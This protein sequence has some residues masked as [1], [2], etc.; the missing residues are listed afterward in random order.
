[1]KRIRPI[2]LF[3]CV[4]PPTFAQLPQPITPNWTEV[5][6]GVWKT[7]IGTAESLTL[8]KAAGGK[9]ATRALAALPKAA[10][11]LDQKEIEGR[12]HN[13][14]TTVRFPLTGNEDIYG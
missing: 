12:I 7:T 1:M 13:H 14:R 4:I 5:A 10:F 3:C 9:P 11:P 2:L 8:L 6:P